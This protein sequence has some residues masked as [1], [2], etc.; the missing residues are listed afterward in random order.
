MKTTTWPDRLNGATST[1]LVPDDF[2]EGQ[3]QLA[4]LN[5]L[6]HGD[7]SI[8]KSAKLAWV[9][10]LYHE[11]LVRRFPTFADASTR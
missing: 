11:S 1:F 8:V 7:I 4:F 10:R 3:D 5:E 9:T 6:E 2:D